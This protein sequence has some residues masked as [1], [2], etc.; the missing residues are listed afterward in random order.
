MNGR[1]KAGEESFQGSDARKK[2]SGKTED[3]MDRCAS[4]IP[5]D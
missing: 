4:K 2:D 3:E 5:V 1:R